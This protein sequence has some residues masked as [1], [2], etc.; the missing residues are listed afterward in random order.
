MADKEIDQLTHEI[1]KETNEYARSLPCSQFDSS[2]DDLHRMFHEQQAAD[3]NDRPLGYLEGPA[4]E[5]PPLPPNLSAPLSEERK[6][7]IDDLRLQRDEHLDV[8]KEQRLRLQKAQPTPMDRSRSCEIAP[9]P[10]ATAHDIEESP[11]G[12]KKYRGSDAVIINH[13]V[14]VQGACLPELRHLRFQSVERTKPGFIQ[15]ED[16]VNPPRHTVAQDYPG[17]F[18]KDRLTLPQCFGNFHRLF[19]NVPGDIMS[20]KCSFLQ[21]CLRDAAHRRTL[22]TSTVS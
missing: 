3:M 15:V 11:V 8:A 4:V 2:A 21:G 10:R 9:D 7:K 19:L 13:V 17:Q 1:W 20:L 22:P 16:K 18:T 5:V 6:A 12:M 14:A